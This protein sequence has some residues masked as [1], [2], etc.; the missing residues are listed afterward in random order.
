MLYRELQKTY[1]V[2]GILVS[3]KKGF[4]FK[5]FIRTQKIIKPL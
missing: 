2:R 1:F 4:K 3:L 5:N